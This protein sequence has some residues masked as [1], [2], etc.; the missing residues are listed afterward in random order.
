[1][2]YANVSI[3]SVCWERDAKRAKEDTSELA[4]STFYR[5]KICRCASAEKLE[6]EKTDFVDDEQWM[7]ERSKTT[8]CDDV[9]AAMMNVL[10]ANANVNVYLYTDFSL[11]Q[12]EKTS[13]HRMDEEKKHFTHSFIHSW[14]ELRNDLIH[15][16]PTDLFDIGSALQMDCKLPIAKPQL[17]VIILMQT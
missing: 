17:Y 5:T 3:T 10:N 6:I 1:M 9:V 16:F 15:F 7:D 12:C 11:F 14:R 13:K 2:E 4:I 8:Y